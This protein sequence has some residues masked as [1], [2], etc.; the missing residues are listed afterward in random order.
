MFQK[1]VTTLRP[2]KVLEL[3]GKERDIFGIDR[4]CIM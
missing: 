4:E 1:G 2:C 3:D